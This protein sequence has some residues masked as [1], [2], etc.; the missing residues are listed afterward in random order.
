VLLRPGVV[1][2]AQPERVD[3]E[4]PRLARAAREL[5]GRL[6][7]PRRVWQR[8]LDTWVARVETAGRGLA[9]LDEAGFDTALAE[10]GVQLRR[11]GLQPALLPRGF[12]L[13]REAARRTLG[14][15]HYGVQLFGGRVMTLGGLAE[16]ET[17]EGKTL[18]A[19][20]PAT[21][22]ALAAIPV[23]VITAN[24]Y[25]VERDAESMAPLYARLGV[26]VGTVVE[27]QP[28]RAARRAAYACDVT[29]VTNKQVAFDYLRDSIAGASDRR[30][31]HRL[32]LEPALSAPGDSQP[33]LR[34]LCFAVVDEAD[35]VL[36]DD[37][38]T[39][40]ILSRPGPAEDENTVHEALVLA[41]GLER[42]TDYRVDRRRGV[43]E[44][45]AAGRTRLDMLGRHL[46]GPLAGARR[47]EEWVCRALAA[48][49]LF[50]R[51]RHYLV[52]EGAIEII[53]LPTGRRAPDRAFEGGMQALIEA[54]ER[55][56]ITPRR[57]TLARISYQRFFRRYLRLCG[58]T[59]TAREVSREL[60]RVYGL[61]TVIV[62]TRLESR[63]QDLGLRVLPDD[64]AHWAATVERIGEL[65]RSGRPV[66][67][68]TST[69]A[70][71]EHLSE[72]LDRAGLPHSV[73]SARQDREEAQ[74]VARAGEAGRITVATRMAG[75]GT[76]IRL[77]VGVEERGGLAVVATEMGEA[78]RI[79]RQLFGR[80]GRQGQ[81][82]S[83]EQIVA[84]GTGGRAAPAAW[85][86]SALRALRLGRAASILALRIAQRAE[87]R[88]AALIRRRLLASERWLGEILAFSQRRS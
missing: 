79:D 18:T 81:P 46:A 47:R 75:R 42:H 32:G 73:L 87:E 26:R 37:A 17:G 39:P 41:E 53:D 72:L 88:R 71:S 9:D 40:L 44:L 62:P 5:E 63:R 28:E 36:I 77:G 52:R 34:G 19:T 22:A 10:Q 84:A 48:E 11:H 59:G 33:V 16:M 20:L 78:R 82:G 65:R 54:R 21:L 7:T 31:A 14:T 74:V 29:Y 1:Q 30:L 8:E 55:V 58:M 43:V 76:D 13:V 66:L 57:E 56:P 27:S 12:A 45:T 35:S 4:A 69:V 83:F 85:F 38:R 68:G 15:P 60:W 49:H 61:P 67:V 25:L 24:D 86:R 3:A 23:H 80:C 70:T 6:L 50:E 64:E 2:G 51:D